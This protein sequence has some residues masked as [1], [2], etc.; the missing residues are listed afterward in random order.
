MITDM[1]TK[2]DELPHD[3]EAQIERAYATMGIEPPQ[4]TDLH[5]LNELGWRELLHPRTNIGRFARKPRANTT[6]EDILRIAEPH[7]ATTRVPPGLPKV[8]GKHRTVANAIQNPPALNDAQLDDAIQ[9]AFEVKNGTPDERLNPIR[10]AIEMLVDEK[11]R[12]NPIPLPENTSEE[13][14]E[15]EEI[16]IL[17]DAIDREFEPP[18]AGYLKWMVENLGSFNYQELLQIRNNYT[19]QYEHQNAYRTKDEK[20]IKE[21]IDELIHD[22]LALRAYL[23]KDRRDREE[24]RAW[25]HT[26]AVVAA[27]RG[28]EPK[29]PKQRYP[30]LGDNPYGPPGGGGSGGIG[31]WEQAMRE[32]RESMRLI[33][34]GH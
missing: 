33:R 22:Q 34:A 18:D 29:L 13:G 32:E 24:D 16:Q 2:F 7:R 11:H 6:P 25:H 1:G 23:L 26:G 8:R 3:W 28:L 27:N 12:R 20:R 4:A 9:T 10:D 30:V 5:G 19:K 21:L 14:L 17:Q 31:E 15:P